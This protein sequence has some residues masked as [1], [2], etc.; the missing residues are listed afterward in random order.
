MPNVWL[1]PAAEADLLDIWVYL[2]EVSEEAADEQLSRLHKRM[3]VLAENPM[4]GRLRSELLI[5][6]LR[7]FVVGSYVLFYVPGD[8]GICVIRVLHS[9]RDVPSAL[10]SPDK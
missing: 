5:P 8:S 2:S 6:D 9:R 7:S 3:S 4:L 1:R 10:A